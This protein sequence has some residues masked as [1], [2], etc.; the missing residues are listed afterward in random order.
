[1]NL[2]SI[3]EYNKNHALTT[4][5][6]TVSGLIW[7]LGIVA[8]VAGFVNITL[9]YLGPSSGGGVNYIINNSIGQIGLLLLFVNTSNVDKFYISKLEYPV[10]CRLIGSTVYIAHLVSVFLSFR[11]P[12]NWLWCISG[13]LALR[14][15]ANTQLYFSVKKHTPDHPWV[16]LLLVWLKRSFLALILILAYSVLV[17]FLT[18]PRLYSLT[19]DLSAEEISTSPVGQALLGAVHT[20]LN[21]VALIPIITRA[22]QQVNMKESFPREEIDNHNQTINEYYERNNDTQSN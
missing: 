1:M 4:V 7:L 5:N 22:I 9:P 6:S 15:L 21:L 17:L 12:S 16:P 14:T 10:S 19:Y 2:S 11:N 8:I 3:E 18:N 13:I 20:I